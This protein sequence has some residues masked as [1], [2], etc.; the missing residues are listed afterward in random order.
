[1]KLSLP[2]LFVCAFAVSFAVAQSESR[3]TVGQNSAGS[4]GSSQITN[5]PVA[6]YISAS[7]CTIG[8]S[9]SASGTMSLQYGTDRTRMTKTADAV[10]GKDGRNYHAQLDSLKPNT[11]YYFQVLNSGEPMG[12]VGTFET[13]AQGDAPTRSRAT[14]PQ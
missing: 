13:V 9:A 11:R 3:N 12:A 1:M 5:G 10:A 14:I 6:E 7:N 8:W 2:F 4:T